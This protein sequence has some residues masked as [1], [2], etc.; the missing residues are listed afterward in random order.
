MSVVDTSRTTQAPLAYSAAE[1]AALIGV[2]ERH[3]RYLVAEGHIPRVP[4]TKRLLIPA[5][6][7]EEWLNS[8]AAADAA[9]IESA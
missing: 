1:F 5:R 4:H 7:G 3:V 9:G 2:S 8:A 6:A